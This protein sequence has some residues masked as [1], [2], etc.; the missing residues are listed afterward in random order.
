MGKK[1]KAS[2]RSAQA[3]RPEALDPADARLGPIST[4]ADVANSEDEYFLNREN[5]MLD[6][7]PE[8][9]RRRK[10]DEDIELSD[11]EI[12]GYEESDSDDATQATGS[13]KKRIFQQNHDSSD[14]ETR[15]R[16]QQDEGWWGDS[17]REYYDAD[18]IETEA[19]ALEEE[20]EA[21]RLQKK[22]LS[23]MRE[24][25]FVFDGDAWLAPEPEA[26]KE[27]ETVFE[28]L[29]EIPVSDDMDNQERSKLL[30][31]RY[32]EF[33][34]LAIEFQ[35]LLSVLEVFKAD[36][37]AE[38]STSLQVVKYWTLGCYVAALASYFAIMTCPAR[39]GESVAR[40]LAPSELR[41][42]G[43]MEALVK[44]RNAWQ[45]IKQAKAMTSSADISLPETD[46][47]V[48]AG[49]VSDLALDK[50]A[51]E[52]LSK[53]N[54]TAT[55]KRAQK[56]AKA[57]AIEAS[58][59]DLYHL[60][61]LAASKSRRQAKSSLQT[62]Q[63]LYQNSDFGEEEALDSHTAAEKAARK[64]SLKF[65]TSQIVQKAS[66]RAG[67]GRDAGGDADIPYRERFRDKQARLLAEA[68]KRGS[69]ESKHGADLDGKSDDDDDARV[70]T[71]VR[72]DEDG[73]YDMVAQVAQAAKMKRQNRQARYAAYAAAGKADRVVEK[74]E[75]GQDGKRKVS[76]AIEKNKG[77]APR[78]SKDVRNPRVK[79]RKQYEA[80]QKKLKSVKPIWQ[81]GEPKG[82]YQGE[83]SGI[84]TAVVKST[85]L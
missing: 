78:R 10:D 79:R 42:H 74:E 30:A 5:I 65:Y 22:K 19:D 54:N 27:K 63:S 75:I 85:K 80:K 8:S 70:A 21:K 67:A 20:A 77:L 48:D 57:K 40:P 9:K 12:L 61:A 36:A 32:P 55:A 38:P 2:G 33:Q 62:G 6:D 64:K 16:S 53:D 71:A 4:Y 11:E 72:D 84:N 44:C 47:L 82:G 17:K 23:K 49:I 59:A 83:L 43:V 15:T 66:R 56:L 46:F 24:Q 51:S 58:V 26:D 34:H 39:D 1:R 60:P 41:D 37:V 52:K 13:K 14:E 73:L 45:R 18:N 68:K 25:D 7:E 3:A 31:A 50:S 35:N 28:V 76:Y 29:E 81:G 69:K